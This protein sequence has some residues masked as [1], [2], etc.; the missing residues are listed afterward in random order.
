MQADQDLVEFHLDQVLL[1]QV[2]VEV[3]VEQEQLQLLTDLMLQDQ[4]E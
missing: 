3:L 1:Q 2:V 4:E